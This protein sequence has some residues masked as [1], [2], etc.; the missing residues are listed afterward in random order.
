MDRPPEI[1][2]ENAKKRLG[3]DNIIFIDVRDAASYSG[4]HIPYAIHVHDANIADFIKETDKNKTVIVYCYHGNSSLGGAAYLLENGFEDVF[5]MEGGF[6]EWRVAYPSDT[7]S[8][9]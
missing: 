9:A 6:E 3:E 7:Q 1:S 2:T 5:S 8:S 4:S